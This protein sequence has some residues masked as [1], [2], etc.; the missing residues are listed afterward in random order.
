M[1]KRFFI[2]L[3]ALLPLCVKAQRAVGS[4][5]VYANFLAPE[6]MLETPDKVFFLSS[7]SLFSFDKDSEELY[8]YGIHNVLSEPTISK[9]FYNGKKDYIALAYNTGNIDIIKND[10]KVVNLPDIRDAVLQSDRTINDISFGNG[11]IYV[12]TNFGIV[13][14]DDS[15]Y[16]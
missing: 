15:R 6:Q 4:W 2:L 5:E 8:Q 10:G 1:I 9:I 14:Y 3:V 11:R 16:I 12:A 13:I 7:G